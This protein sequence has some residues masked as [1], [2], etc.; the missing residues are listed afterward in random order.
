MPAPW[1][2]ARSLTQLLAQVNR[3]CPGRAKGCDGV[4]GDAA[5]QASGG[6]HCP[7]AGGVVRALDLTND[8]ESGL[9]SAH[10]ADALVASRDTRIKYVISA[11]RIC[12]STITPWQWR[13]YTGTNPHRTHVHLSVVDGINGDDPRPWTLKARAVSGPVV[14]TYP[15]LVRLGTRG[16][17]V[18]VVQAR[19]HARGWAVDVDGIAGLGTVA[20]VKGFQRQVELE[21]D[22]VVG[23]ATWRM[24][25]TAKVTR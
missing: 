17:R 11:G 24:L 20:A 5:H 15:G 14:P 13:K 1:R 16:A 4:I 2:P 10:L 9:T 8:P 23:Q 18:F 3:S 25:W 19:L 12:S 7:D 21:Q 22:G 6:D